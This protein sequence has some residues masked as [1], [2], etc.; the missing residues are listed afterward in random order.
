VLGRGTAAA[1]LMPGE[2]YRAPAA[3]GLWRIED[4]QGREVPAELVAAA[5]ATRLVS[6][7]LERPG[8]YRVVQGATVRST[9][10][11]NPDPRESDL[12]AL[13]EAV[14]LRA[15]PAGRAQVV[16]PGADLARRVRE[17]RFGRELWSWFVGLALLLLVTESVIGRLGLAGSGGA[18]SPPRA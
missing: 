7:P 11:V 9:F 14:L 2:R 16:Q 10:A 18:T 4:E 17:A 5:G 13:P 1:S 3:T 6:A 8:L 12:A 15:F